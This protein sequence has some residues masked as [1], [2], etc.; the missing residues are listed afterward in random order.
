VQVLRREVLRRELLELGRE[1]RDEDV[2]DTRVLDQL[3]APF[4]RREQLDLVAERDARVRV[5]RDDG[6][7]ETRLA[8]DVED[9]AMTPMH[10]VE[11]ADGDRAWSSLELRR[12]ARD[13]HE[14]LASAASDSIIRSGSASST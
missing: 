14:S 5:E 3:E 2:L 11:A 8:H 1:R 10:A 6:R 13:R 4:E 7:D 9:S 12:A